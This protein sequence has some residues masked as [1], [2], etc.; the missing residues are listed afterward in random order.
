[1]EDQCL[2]TLQSLPESSGT[3]TIDPPLLRRFYTH[4]VRQPVVFD[5]R[6]APCPL[7]T[8]LYQY[9]FLRP[10]VQ[11]NLAEFIVSHWRI[12]SAEVQMP[13][14]AEDVPPTGPEPLIPAPEPPPIV[15]RFT[16]P[17]KRDDWFDRF[18][19]VVRI[20]LFR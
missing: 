9:R 17:D 8:L 16:S 11:V 4:C 2:T 19:D 18:L 1:M 3:A 7:K 6:L 12:F 5:Q 13:E 15:P 20:L 14:T 10:E